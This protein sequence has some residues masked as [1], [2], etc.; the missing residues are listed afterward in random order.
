MNS[1]DEVWVI[2]DDKSIRWVLEKALQKAQMQVETFENG[3]TLLDRL[4]QHQP[5]AILSDVRMPGIDGFELL[6]LIKDQ[7][8]QM[9]VIIMTAHSDLDP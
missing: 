9:P 1:S 3:E 4:A 7:Y 6:Q 5:N 8:P 2:D